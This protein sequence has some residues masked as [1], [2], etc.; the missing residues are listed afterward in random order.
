MSPPTDSRS[1]GARLAA[2]LATVRGTWLPDDETGSLARDAVALAT[3]DV[4]GGTGEVARR[5]RRAFHDELTRVATA[6]DS[7]DGSI[8]PSAAL[9]EV[10]S[11]PDLA[12]ESSAPSLV[13]LAGVTA[14]ASLTT[15]FRATYGDCPPAAEDGVADAL[16][17]VAADD[18]AAALDRAA[19]AG[20]ALAAVTPLTG[21]VD[22][23]VD[24][25]RSRLPTDADPTPFDD[26]VRDALVSGDEA[27][28]DR[29]ERR[30]EAAEDAA[31]SRA[32]L[33]APTPDA[34]EGLVADLW[35]DA[36]ETE[37]AS[38]TRRSGDG[39]VDVVVR[40]DRG[41]VAVIQ[42]KQF[43]PD[44]PVGRPTIQQLEGAVSQFDAAAGYVVSSS[45]FTGP[46]RAA[47][48]ALD[49]MTLVDGGT[50][51]DLLDASRL[52]PPRALHPE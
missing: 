10:L 31:W 42:V 1:P 37:T 23:L 6:L 51:R 48:E 4:P 12:T 26:A 49:A 41:G 17:A 21:R 16:S 52:V 5:R 40:F 38:R 33:L 2:S 44:N 30:V 29:L 20:E 27:R 18:S 25:A 11:D 7:R 36:A 46:A 15:A 50:L 43:A 9:V 24:A 35:R 47:A 45:G 22:R 14:V 28:L 34:F 19:A 3:R 8:G 39:G 32:D 13:T